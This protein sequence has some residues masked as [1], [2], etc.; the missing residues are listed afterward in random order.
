MAINKKQKGTNKVIY[1]LLAFVI[2]LVLLFFVML[3]NKSSNYQNN[4]PEALT[5]IPQKKT[6]YSK[7]MKVSVDM[8]ISFQVEESFTTITFKKNDDSITLS[9]NG[10]QFSNLES[11]L[12]DFDSK[13]QLIVPENNEII[14]NGYDT[15]LRTMNF[16]KQNIKQKSYYIYVDN[17]VYVI[18]TKSKSLFNDLDQIA[19][20]FRYTP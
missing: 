2:L 13:R 14:I 9:R 7:S 3:L 1:L 20:S 12:N 19:R 8:P 4:N 6:Y 11:Y 18:F 10:T 16:P 17:W 5:E 15:V